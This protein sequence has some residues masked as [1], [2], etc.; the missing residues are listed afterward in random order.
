MGERRLAVALAVIALAA[1]AAFAADAQPKDA[2]DLS[3]IWM[4]DN[5]LDEKMKRE[6]RKRQTEAE[7]RAERPQPKALPL[8]PA[9][10]AIYK[11]RQAARDA[12]GPHG[13][14]IPG[15][16]DRAEDAAEDLGPGAE[17]GGVEVACHRLGIEDLR[18]NFRVCGAAGIEEQARVVRL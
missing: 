12:C 1:G 18:C 11:A 14:G 5:T 2:H 3:G 10:Q 7:L 4:N 15:G 9:Y 6:G 16:S 13:R 17:D 8:T